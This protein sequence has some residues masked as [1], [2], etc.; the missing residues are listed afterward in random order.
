MSGRVLPIDT[1]IDELLSITQ[2]ASTIILRH[3]HSDVK[4]EYKSD[5]SPVTA[6]DIE[7]N[8]YIVHALSQLTPEIP[9]IAEE[10]NGN[11]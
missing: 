1:I 3:Y 6:A 2:H 5:N 4:I 8:N 11:G 7:S 9:I 10:S